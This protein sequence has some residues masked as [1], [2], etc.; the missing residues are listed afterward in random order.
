T[1]YPGDKTIHQLFA[2]QAEKS[3]D[4][5]AFVGADLRVCPNCLTY[6]ELNKQSDRLAGLLIEKGVQPDTIVAIMMERTIEMVIG[7]LG[8]MKAGGA[9]LPIDPNYPQERIDYML[10][11]S[12]AAILLTDYEREQRV[13]CQL[14]MVEQREASLH[15]SSFSIQHS[16][17]L[18]YVIYTSGSTGKPKGALVEYRGMMNHLY[19][20][21]DDLQINAESIVA[22]TASHTFDISIWQFFAALLVGGKIIIYS[23]S[24]LL[25][26]DMFIS[27]LTQDLITIMEV[28]PSYLSV[29]FDAL[30]RFGQTTLTLKHLLVTGE[31]LKPYL[32]KKWFKLFPGIRMVNAYGPTEA[33][34]DITHYIMDKMPEL[35]SIP[36]G[37]P[38]QN[39]KIYIIDKYMNLCPIG[40]KGEIVVSGIGVGRGYLNNEERTHSV[41]M[42]DPFREKK[43]IRL[44]KTGDLGR[45]LPDGN[46]EFFGRKDYQVKIKGFRI[47][48]GEIEN[49]LLEIHPIEEAV[50][51]DRED[52]QGNKYLCAYMVSSAELNP[53]EIKK[54]LSV[55]FPDYMI[56]SYFVQVEKIPLTVNGKVERR[57]LPGIELRAGEGY[58]AA[59]DEFERKLVNIW[60]EVL[61]IAHDNIG[62]DDNFFELGGHSLKATIL[63]ARIH[64]TFNVNIPLAEIF[65]KSTIRG[66]ANYIKSAVKE[67]YISIES[68][69]KKEYYSLSSAQKRL[70]ILY[71]MEDQGVGYNI[72]SFSV[73]DGEIDKNRFE[74][75]FTLLIDRHESLR[76]SFQIINDEPVQRIHDTV[77]F[78]I[79]KL[80]G[81][82]DPLW[83]PFIRPFALSKAPLLRVGLQKIKKDKHILMVDM[84]HIISDGIS[85][86][87]LVKD[88]MALYQEENLDKLQLQY[89]DFSVWQTG[90]K[91]KES[92]KRQEA[93]WLNEFAGEIPVL[94]LPVDYPRPAIQNFEGNRIQFEIDKESTVV[95]K[96]LTLKTGAT[97]YM[98]LLALYTIFLSKLTNQEDIVTGSPIAGR[99]HPDLKKIIGMFVNTLALRNY[100]AGEKKFPDFL[101]EIKEKTLKAFEFQDYQYDDL[102]EKVVLTRDTS[103]NPL[104]DTMLVLQNIEIAEVNIPGLKLSPYP[105]ENKTAK[106]DLTLTAFEGEEKLLFNFEYCTKL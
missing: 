40:V 18:A 27:R 33:S 47:E 68:T 23:H 12:A 51:I 17:H 7:L 105:Y 89:K 13:D 8:I 24:L 10:K 16:S 14:T 45:W 29:L 101:E 84:H 65:K 48:C 76:T 2:E 9:Y 52:S 71:R 5:I 1:D 19:I 22:Q 86:N 82:G 20:K 46:I 103:R 87:I 93:F 11:D 25:E 44:Y 69:E 63:T 38:L 75:T 28:V 54:Q 78:E 106:F 35:E 85:M 64:K 97:L 39:L 102:V 62:I 98:L 34:D 66:L 26:P 81:R 31:E 73:L 94:E 50:V 21:I 59:R 61:N 72:P 79:E 77:E 30:E 55:I 74:Q 90:E 49:R 15:H 104:F 99:K 53:S 70:Y 41:F 83:S 60:N 92:I 4:S 80:E 58:I 36:I 100:P 3:P 6:H 95:L 37:R 43:E 57:A 96:D 42:A 91:Q 67:K 32:V 88:F 56:P